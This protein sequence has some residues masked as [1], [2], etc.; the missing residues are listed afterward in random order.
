MITTDFESDISVNVGRP[1]LFD[2]ADMSY[3]KRFHEFIEMTSIKIRINGMYG[4][5]E[6]KIATNTYYA[7]GGMQYRFWFNTTEDK[8][9]FLVELKLQFPSHVTD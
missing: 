7:G 4:F 9:S 2:D 5:I 6:G 1:N 3:W 8:E